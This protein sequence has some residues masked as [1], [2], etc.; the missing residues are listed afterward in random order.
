MDNCKLLYETIVKHIRTQQAPESIIPLLIES[1]RCDNLILPSQFM[2]IRDQYLRHSRKYFPE[3]YNLI[4][5]GTLEQNSNEHMKIHAKHYLPVL[6]NSIV[7]E[8][9]KFMRI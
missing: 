3:E 4:R 9:K 5:Q 2:F 1:R 7:V 8:Q 6:L